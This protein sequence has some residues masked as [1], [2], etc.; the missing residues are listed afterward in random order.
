MQT[1][2]KSERLCGKKSI[3]TLFSDGDA[4][5]AYPCKIIWIKTIDENTQPVKVLIT[6]SKRNFKKAAD[7]NKI[8]RLIREV[9]RKNKYILYESLKDNNVN[10][11]FA[12][13]YTAKQ[14]IPYSE[15][16]V[17]II[18]MLN[19]LIIEYEKTTS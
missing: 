12:I 17:K 16:Q 19:R 3:N 10:I 9:Y 11:N 14:I 2:K 13:I 5:F 7:R 18:S 6:V 15:L 4:L 1:F 8:K